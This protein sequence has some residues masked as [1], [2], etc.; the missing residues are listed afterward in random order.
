MVVYT[1]WMN[2]T[3]KD[4]IAVLD[5]YGIDHSSMSAS[6]VKEKA[7]TLLAE[8][9]CRCIGKADKAKTDE[10]KSRAIGV[11]RRNVLH[12]KGIDVHKFS[13]DEGAK[14][15]PNKEG[16]KIRRHR[17]SV[18]KSSTRKSSTRRSSA[19]KSS[20]RRVRRKR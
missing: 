11:C 20:T 5:Y 13:C 3:K 2:I 8:K 19:R 10:S 9:L 17:K 7:E 1:S 12:R 6:K 15:L 18:S 4:H 16:R 14:L